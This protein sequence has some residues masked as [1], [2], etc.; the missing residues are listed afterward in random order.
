MKLLTLGI[1]MTVCLPLLAQDQPKANPV[2]KFAVFRTAS[3]YRIVAFDYRLIVTFASMQGDCKVPLS[4]LQLKG[5]VEVTTDGA[6]LKA[7]EADYHCD[8]G[9]IEPLGNVHMKVTPSP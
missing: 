3:G 5:N 4:S 6:V 1:A 7:D 8:T 9:E 2:Y